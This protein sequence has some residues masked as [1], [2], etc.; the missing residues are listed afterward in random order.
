M[1]LMS[2][3]AICRLRLP[4]ELNAGLPGIPLRAARA[5]QPLFQRTDDG[6]I[7]VDS[8]TV[9]SS[10]LRPH[11]LRFAE[12]PI[13][14]KRILWAAAPLRAGGTEQALISRVRV[15]LPRE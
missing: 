1:I 5:I 11:A 7:L 15:D 13:Q 3:L 6:Q 8:P 2:V 12:D 10:D 14:Q 4:V 9:G